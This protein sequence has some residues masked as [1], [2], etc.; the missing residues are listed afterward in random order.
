ML[1]AV[2]G[3]YGTM[4]YSVARRRNE[5]GV[6]LALGAAPRT[7]LGETLREVGVTTAFGLALGVAG[8]VA[9]LRLLRGLLFD[10]APNDLPTMAA[11]VA[12]LATCAIV[13]GYLPA[14][15]A[16]RTDPMLSMR[17]D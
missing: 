12:A 6:R 5:I 2:I 14:R 8:S 3:L 1:L 15:R 4:S 9:G 10:V 11:A 17:N 16:A 13:A 7:V